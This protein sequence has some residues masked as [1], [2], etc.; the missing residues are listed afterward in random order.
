MLTVIFVIFSGLF[1]LAG[2]VTMIALHRAVDGVE[3]LEGF[4]RLA[5]DYRD[6]S[7]KPI[8][9]TTGSDRAKMPVSANVRL[10]GV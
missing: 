5:L 7:Q 3:T 6:K 8:R 2:I 1:L 9:A 10:S 4:V